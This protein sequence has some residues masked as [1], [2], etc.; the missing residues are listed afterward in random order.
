MFSSYSGVENTI[1]AQEFQKSKIGRQGQ[2]KDEDASEIS[3]REMGRWFGAANS[4][5]L[6][7]LFINRISQQERHIHKQ[8]VRCYEEYFQISY[9]NEPLIW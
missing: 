8:N 9:G 6:T 5:A 7:K 1:K 3:D 4:A 2:E